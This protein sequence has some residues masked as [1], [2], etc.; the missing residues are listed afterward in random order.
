MRIEKHLNE[1]IEACR[2]FNVAS[3]HI[4][5]SVARGETESNSDVDFLVRFNDLD[6][7]GIA[8]RYFEF[9]QLLESEL[10]RKVDL[11][12]GAYPS[13]CAYAAWLMGCGN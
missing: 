4:V 9:Q 5:G 10:G 11:I 6:K 2:R 13:L 1:V 7:L 8:D 12:D 3:L